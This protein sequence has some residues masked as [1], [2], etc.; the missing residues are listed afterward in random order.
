MVAT[1]AATSAFEF[2]SMALLLPKPIPIL[3]VRGVN[4]I[5]GDAEISLD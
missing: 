5:A 1:T 2:K 4:E 3:L